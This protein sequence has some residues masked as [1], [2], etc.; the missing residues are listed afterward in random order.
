M[1]IVLSWRT[2]RVLRGQLPV[3]PEVTHSGTYA[4]LTAAGV[5]TAQ[6]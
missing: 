2:A 5:L 3:A 4:E 6:G 1:S